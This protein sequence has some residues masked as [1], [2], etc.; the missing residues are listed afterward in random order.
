[1][2]PTTRGCARTGRDRRGRGRAGDPLSDIG[3]YAQNF[4]SPPTISSIDP[5]GPAAHSGLVVGDVII[6][7]DGAPVA[8]MAPSAVMTLATNHR[9]GT[10]LAVGTPRGTFTIVVAA[11]AL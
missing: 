11:N 8:T 2:G 1:M 5:A 3:F 6:A 4:G 7:L 10:M 9:P